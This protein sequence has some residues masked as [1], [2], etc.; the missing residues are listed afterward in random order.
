M[1]KSY[2]TNN[3]VFGSLI[4]LTLFTWLIGKQ[5][6]TDLLIGPLSWKT[7]FTILLVTA[8]IKIQL[9]G[10]FFMHLRSVNGFWR[11]IITLW[12]VFTGSLITAAF[13]L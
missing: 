11:W 4:F 10:D 8:V 1:L 7:S 2:R 6:I 12:V 13:F 9:I 5:D 3:I